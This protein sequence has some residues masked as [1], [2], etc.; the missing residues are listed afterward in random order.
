MIIYN[1]NQKQLWRRI[2]RDKVEK[3]NFLKTTDE[4]KNVN[5][6]GNLVEDNELANYSFYK[7]IQI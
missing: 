2:A 5:S 7:N 4:K 1:G 6:I 3:P